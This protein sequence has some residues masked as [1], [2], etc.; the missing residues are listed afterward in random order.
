MGDDGVRGF[1]ALG[2]LCRWEGE[3]I[4]DGCDGKGELTHHLRTAS[5]SRSIGG[6]F[7]GFGILGWDGRGGLFSVRL[8][9]VREVL[10]FGLVPVSQ[11]SFLQ[12]MEGR[13]GEE[14]VTILT[15]SC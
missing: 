8:E 9:K 5:G 12:V 11:T 7:G 14:V 6:D 4:G 15:E 13:D 3:R 1:G 2:E 10:A